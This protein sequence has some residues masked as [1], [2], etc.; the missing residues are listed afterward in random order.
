MCPVKLAAHWCRSFIRQVIIDSG[1]SA[2][3]SALAITRES[4][5]QRSGISRLTRTTS[6]SDNTLASKT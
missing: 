2:G 1:S 3:R 4:R 5:A 6:R